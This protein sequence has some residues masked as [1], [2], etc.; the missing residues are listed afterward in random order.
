MRQEH[1][2]RAAVG[3]AEAR[4]DR[5]GERVVDADER[6]REREA[7][8]RRGVGHVGARPEVVAVGDRARQRVEDQVHR[9]QAE[10]VGVRRR[11]DRD[12]GL[13][14]VGQRVDAGV[15]RHLRRQRQREPRIDD[16]DVGHER[17]VD[18]RELAAARG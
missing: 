3:D 5:V 4:A 10:G 16:G 11:E 17:V 2:V 6:V 9:L 15:G 18:E 13:E 1:A 12:V 7:R 14:R 8:D